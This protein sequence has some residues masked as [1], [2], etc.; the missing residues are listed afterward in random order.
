MHPM[1]KGSLQWRMI[2]LDVRKEYGGLLKLKKK[3]L[4]A[5]E[6][7]APIVNLLVYHTRSPFVHSIKFYLKSP[8]VSDSSHPTL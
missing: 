2:S 6:V 5:K 8:V 4:T 3:G 1:S 7:S